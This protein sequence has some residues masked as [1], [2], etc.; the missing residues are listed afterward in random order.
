MENNQL[1]QYLCK[2]PDWKFKKE[3][4]KEN[5]KYMQECINLKKEPCTIEG[6][7]EF[8]KDWYCEFSKKKIAK[9]VLDEFKHGDRFET[10]YLAEVKMTLGLTDSRNASYPPQKIFQQNLDEHLKR[11]ALSEIAEKHS[12]KYGTKLSYET[13]YYWDQEFETSYTHLILK[14]LIFS[15]KELDSIFHATKEWEELLDNKK[16]QNLYGNIPKKIKTDLKKI[17]DS[18][19]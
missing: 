2:L 7:I 14:R 15:P 5:D 16:Y 12:L 9:E 11:S 13:N 4:T 17:V 3:S 6:F 18:L 10:T 19:T 1:L 8:E